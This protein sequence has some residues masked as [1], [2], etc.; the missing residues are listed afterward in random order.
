M[1]SRSP[2]LGSCPVELHGQADAGHHAS[3]DANGYS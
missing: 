2:A 3:G 1:D